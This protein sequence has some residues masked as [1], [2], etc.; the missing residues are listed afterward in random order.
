MIIA[1]TGT[2]GTGKSTLAKKLAVY[3]K[4]P[5]IDV[6][7]IAKKTALKK[8][9]NEYTANLEK[10]RKKLIK[11]IKNKKNAV[12]ESH[13]LVEVKLPVDLL[14]ILRCSPRELKQRLKKRS[15]SKRKTLDNLLCETQNY[16]ATRAKLNYAKTKIVEINTTK[17]PTLAQF[18]RKIKT[19][20]EVDFSKDLKWLAKIDAVTPL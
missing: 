14:V 10:L 12:L 17:F 2:P 20:D 19:S 13:L 15:Y 16:F 3:L 18:M 8:E 5:L 6:E 11:V 4:F 9:N 7:K 1:I